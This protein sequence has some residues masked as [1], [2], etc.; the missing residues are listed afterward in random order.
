MK[1]VQYLSYS[2]Q[3]ILYIKKLLA[4]IYGIRDATDS[5]IVSHAVLKCPL[6]KTALL[7]AAKNRSL[8]TYPTKELQVD[9][10]INAKILALKQELKIKDTKVVLSCLLRLMVNLYKIKFIDIQDTVLT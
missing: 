1:T 6:N 9:D 7:M 8:F 4:N 10:D 2:G 3:D 5:Q